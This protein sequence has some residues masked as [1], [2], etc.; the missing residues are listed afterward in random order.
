MHLR[1]LP[2][3]ALSNASCKPFCGRTVLQATAIDLA[4][5]CILY[6]LHMPVPLHS[7]HMPAIFATNAVW[8]G[9]QGVQCSAV[10]A[11]QHQLPISSESMR[12]VAA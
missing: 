10:L 3:C 9:R 8:A 4:Q 11:S 7:S 12:A 1:R 6:C 5:A 2:A